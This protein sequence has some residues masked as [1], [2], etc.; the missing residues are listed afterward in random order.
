MEKTMRDFKQQFVSNYTYHDF[1]GYVEKTLRDFINTNDQAK[2]TIK[3]IETTFSSVN[4]L[5][6]EKAD[7]KDLSRIEKDVK[8]CAKQIDLKDL[9][10]KTFPVLKTFEGKLE[11]FATDIDSFRLMINRFDEILLE[12]ANKVPVEEIQHGLLQLVRLEK[13]VE[14]DM[15][16]SMKR[17]ELQKEVEQLKSRTEYF[18]QNTMQEIQTAVRK[19]TSQL[20]NQIVG[21]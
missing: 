13:V 17:Y 20:R 18:I 19:Q 7:V 9:H 11:E 8:L 1:K 5:L 4:D 12:K 16:Q 2:S 3:M 6:Q 14:L 15:A 10:T 21:N